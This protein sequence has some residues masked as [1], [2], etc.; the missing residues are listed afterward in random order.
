MPIFPPIL[1]S[2]LP[3]ANAPLLCRPCARARTQTVL[4]SHN[5]PGA[6]ARIGWNCLLFAQYM[7]TAAMP[8]Q[9]GGSKPPPAA[10]VFPRLCWPA[11]RWGRQ[12]GHRDTAPPIYS[13]NTRRLAGGSITRHSGRKRFS[14]ENAC[15]P[16][17][18]YY[19][20][21]RRLTPG[22]VGPRATCCGQVVRRAGSGPVKRR[23]KN[24][25]SED[26]KRHGD[27]RQTTHRGT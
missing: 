7:A 5:R 15:G 17:Q 12:A 16:A 4:F 20:L 14:I 6:P 10:C 13:P 23:T 9:P 25:H 11:R 8:G 21:M 1:T 19:R 3:R 26:L 27:D 2:F 22:D 18:H 24:V